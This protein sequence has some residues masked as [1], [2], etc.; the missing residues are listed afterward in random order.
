M[1][2]TLVVAAVG[3]YA[4]TQRRMLWGYSIGPADVQRLEA[5]AAKPAVASHRV[6]VL[7]FN[8]LAVRQA[9]CVCMG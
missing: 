5:L 3:G 7:T 1:V 2:L 8:G 6:G 9:V 4:F